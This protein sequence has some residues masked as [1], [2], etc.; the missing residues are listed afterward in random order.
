MFHDRVD[1]DQDEDEYEEG[2]DEDD[3]VANFDDLSQ[4]N[5]CANLI[6]T[7][8]SA[9]SSQLNRHFGHSNVGQL[10]LPALPLLLVLLLLL[11]R[12]HLLFQLPREHSLTL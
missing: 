6:E 2:D 7:I 1:V 9:G 4:P 10:R 12:L 3:E 5:K 11:V 8:H